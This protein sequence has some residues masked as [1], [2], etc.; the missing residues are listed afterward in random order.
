MMRQLCLLL[1]TKLDAAAPGGAS[2]N[3]R[4]G[5]D[6]HGPR[7]SAQPPFQPRVIP[8]PI[9]RALERAPGLLGSRERA[10]RGSWAG[11][12]KIKGGSRPGPRLHTRLQ[13]RRLSSRIFTTTSFSHYL[14][15][16]V[17]SWCPTDFFLV[18]NHEHHSIGETSI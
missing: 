12:L 17:L 8:H 16:Q 18:F 9:G 2:S 4:W 11:E 5:V 7:R 13:C 3:R 15:L 6:G 1:V 10:G 14:N